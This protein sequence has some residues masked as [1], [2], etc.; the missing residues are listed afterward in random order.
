MFRPFTDTTL[1][2]WRSWLNFR[3]RQTV[4]RLPSVT[5]ER[6]GGLLAGE[7]PPRRTLRSGASGA[8]RR[9]SRPR[10]APS[11][12]CRGGSGCAPGGSRRCRR[13]R[14]RCARKRNSPNLFTSTSSKPAV[15]SLWP[16][17]TGS[18]GT[19][20]SPKWTSRKRTPGAVSIPANS[21]PGLNSS[22]VECGAPRYG[23]DGKSWVILTTSLQR[24]GPPSS[25]DP[26]MLPGPS[27]W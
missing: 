8:S 4:T 7:I 1:L 11:R 22:G 26:A 27:G 17:V 5:I 9:W 20:V 2:V 19:I 12:A 21:P 16:R 13:T 15:W 14:P 18:T 23:K 3:A 24:V 6:D 25:R 10:S